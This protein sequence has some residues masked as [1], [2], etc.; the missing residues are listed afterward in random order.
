MQLL[1]YRKIEKKLGIRFKRRKML[2]RALTHSSYIQITK[3]R[4]HHETYEILEF[5]GDAVLEL[6]T[7]EYLIQKY[8]NAHEGTLS[9]LKKRYTS[10][11]ALY[12]VGKK[13]N[14]GKFLFLDKGEASTGGRVRPSNIAG[15]FEAVIGALYLD[16][17]LPYTEK[18]IRRVILNK[19]MLRTVDYK[20]HLNAW[21]MQHRY[22]LEYRVTKEK[23]APHRKIFHIT[24][25]VNRKKYGTGIGSTKKK[26]EQEAARKFLSQ[27][28]KRK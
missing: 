16:R 2:K 21:A 4:S 10:T 11:D 13:L 27:K 7:R 18:F 20:S 8:P 12:T 24:L 15:C 9:E 14:L 1:S 26:A 28:A 19:R 3:D 17:G 25:Y 22:T 5:L 23:G 6:V